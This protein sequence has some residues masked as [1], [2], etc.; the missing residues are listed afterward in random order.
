MYGWGR[1]PAPP[2]YP[3]KYPQFAESGRWE[4]CSLLVILCLVV[5][6]VEVCSTRDCV[7]RTP[8]AVL[9][10]ATGN[11][12]TPLHMAVNNGGNLA[13]IKAG[14]AALRCSVGPTGAAFDEEGKPVRHSGGGDSGRGRAG[15]W[16]GGARQ[17]WRAGCP[18]LG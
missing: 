16:L 4:R 12:A 18:S 13:V 5:G 10:T 7:S 6:S 17:G 3:L 9:N 11:G 15:R 8:F 14:S 2:V 1:H